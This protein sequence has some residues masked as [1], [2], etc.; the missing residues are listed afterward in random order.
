MVLR[1]A[2]TGWGEQIVVMRL[3]VRVV[4]AV[5]GLARRVTP[6]T[7]ETVEI[8]G[9]VAEAGVRGEMIR[10]PVVTAATV[11][12]VSLLSSLVRTTHDETV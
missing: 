1:Q 9:V 11:V 8:S 5:R 2:E 7:V 3:L 4:A 6:V 10:S 12:R